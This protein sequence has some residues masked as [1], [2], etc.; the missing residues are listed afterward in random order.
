[1]GLLFHVKT[2]ISAIDLDAREISC[3]VSFYFSRGF[4][5]GPTPKIPAVAILKYGV[6]FY[7]SD[8]G[9]DRRLDFRVNVRVRKL[10]VMLKYNRKTKKI[11]TVLSLIRKT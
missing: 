10:R 5:L 8:K 6:F 2:R 1:M 9:E 4:S 3:V 11:Y 7:F